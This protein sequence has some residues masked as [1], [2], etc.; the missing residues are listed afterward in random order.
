M[1]TKTWKTSFNVISISMAI[2][3]NFI[4]FHQKTDFKNVRENFALVNKHL[5]VV[6]SKRETET[7]FSLPPT[8]CDLQCQKPLPR[9]TSSPPR[10]SVR[11]G[12]W[13]SRARGRGRPTPIASHLENRGE[14]DWRAQGSATSKNTE[15]FS[16]Q[17][18]FHWSPFS[19]IGAQNCPWKISP[20]YLFPLTCR[21]IYIYN[22]RKAANIHRD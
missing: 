5:R 3:P 21:L 1:F 8:V 15:K 2:S 12:S 10:N 7:S 6:L 16:V 4:I 9:A 19:T 13:F 14:A 18:P 20:C 17:L 22:A 11:H